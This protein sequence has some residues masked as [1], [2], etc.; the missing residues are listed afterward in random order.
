MY[1]R[2]SDAEARAFVV[3]AEPPS[4]LPLVSTRKVCSSNNWFSGVANWC[5]FS[6]IRSLAVAVTLGTQVGIG[7]TDCERGGGRTQ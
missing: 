3:L 4:P 2:A 5:N 1:S 6:C 7:M